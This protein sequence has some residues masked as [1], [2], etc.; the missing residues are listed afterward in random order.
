MVPISKC[1]RKYDSCMWL[2]V[3]VLAAVLAA[4]GFFAPAA[5]AME[6]G[7]RLPEWLEISFKLDRIPE[8]GEPVG[9]VIRLTAL[10]ADL[11]GCD[12]TVR[13]PRGI[14]VVGSP[15][16]WNCTLKKGVATTLKTMVVC[17]K[18]VDRSAAVLAVK[19]IYPVQKL[20]V[21]VL[22]QYGSDD[23]EARELVNQLDELRGRYPVVRT[24]DF[25]VTG[26]EGF[27]G[28]AETGFGLY[29]E[30]ASVPGD[31][32]FV[33]KGSQFGSDVDKGDAGRTE[34]QV[35]NF[36]RLL[37]IV[38]S[39]P[40]VAKKVFKTGG[41][42]EAQLTEQAERLLF[43]GNKKLLEGKS[44]QAIE[45]FEEASSLDTDPIREVASGNALAVAFHMAGQKA[46]AVTLWSGILKDYP[47]YPLCRYVD[48]NVGIHYLLRG[49]RQRAL[50]FFRNAFIRK[51][52]FTLVKELILELE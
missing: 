2:A 3:G 8:I 11:P 26:Q 33:L 45:L 25:L 16:Q 36:R 13:F 38:A 44:G 27:S 19:T 15:P 37:S 41:S 40:E 20:K 48:Y 7:Y 42:L 29:L 31:L 4:G 39:R 35:A 14:K 22:R 17:T 50:I 5:E 28:S 24:L 43:L 10:V 47:D 46:K 23:P 18:P 21:L 34:R 51:P 52:Q 6:P 49:N 30:N 32:G 9:V 1:K 12:V